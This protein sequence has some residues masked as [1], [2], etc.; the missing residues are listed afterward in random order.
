MTVMCFLFVKKCIT[1]VIISGLCIIV[2]SYM[3]VS[4][5]KLT[6]IYSSVYI[7]PFYSDGSKC[8]VYR[9]LVS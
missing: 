3:L 5:D 4:A 6:S 1:I 2:C 9:T 8:I 7:V